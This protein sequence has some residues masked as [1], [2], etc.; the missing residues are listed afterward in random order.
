M[1]KIVFVLHRPT[2]IFLCSKQEGLNMTISA[3]LE[4]EKGDPVT[5]PLLRIG[6]PTLSSPNMS[7]EL[8]GP[9]S[10]RSPVSLVPQFISPIFISHPII[11]QS[12]RSPHLIGPPS[13]WFLIQLVPHLTRFPINHPPPIPLARLRIGPPSLFFPLCNP[14]Y[15]VLIDAP[16]QCPPPP[17]PPHCNPAHTG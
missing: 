3:Q 10:H 16:F 4:F 17:P 8:V 13:H 5:V 6:P 9:P 12:Q 14:G 11:S 7:F 2:L 15:T 1:I